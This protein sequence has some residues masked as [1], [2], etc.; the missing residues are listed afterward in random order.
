[1]RSLKISFINPPHADWS[2]ANNMTYLQCQSHYTRYG[3]YAE[4]VTWLKAPYKW[5]KYESIK[6]VID[7]I[8]DADIVLF[9]SY[10]WNVDL[11][12]QIAQFLKINNPNIIRVVGG[13]HIGT[14]EPGLLKSRETT[15]FRLSP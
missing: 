5:N 2:L 14:N 12:D 10:T 6:E 4:N 1:M 9:S 11:L 7:E 15:K 13:P 8:R 3:K